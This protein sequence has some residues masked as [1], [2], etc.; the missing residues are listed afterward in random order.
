MSL[1]LCMIV[2]DEV[3]RIAGCLDPVFGL[4][5]ELIVIDTGST[6]G[7]PGLIERRYGVKP[8]PGALEE[9]RCFCK[10]D[11]RN[12]AYERASTDWIL[13]LDADERIDPAALERW[14]R[15]AHAPG[16]AGY[17]GAWI[18]R[19]EG[20]ADYE[21]Y[22]LFLFRRGF[23]KRGVVHENVQVDL[24]EKGAVAGW[25]DGLVVHHHPEG[26]KQPA[27][28]EW[29]RRR[30]ECGLR[31]DPGWRRYD[32]FLGYMSWQEGRVADALAHLGIAARS[33][34]T[35]FPVECLN[36]AMVLAEIYARRGER[37]ALA[38]TLASAQSFFDEAAGDFEVRINFRLGPWLRA[39]AAAGERG[40]L[41]AI[42][43]YRFAR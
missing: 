29:Y 37:E 10:S 6:D 28:N 32:W 17:F 39:A 14:R 12:S 33:R 30:L 36:A 38:A 24:R 21:D 27:K 26:A 16:V 8:L 5:D 34:S 1:A 20:E 43:A 25:L 40:E 11:L 15:M 41:E 42:R 9:A 2:K 22:K 23:R 19:P 3:N 4:L 7:T 13:S 31:L 18:N 35:L